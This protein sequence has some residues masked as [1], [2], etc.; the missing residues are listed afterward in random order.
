MS[1]ESQS[2]PAS[3]TPRDH[4]NPASRRALPY[5]PWHSGGM[6]WVSVARSVLRGPSKGETENSASREHFIEWSL[7]S[8]S[9]LL[10][11]ITDAHPYE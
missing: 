7:E 11:I 4:A 8:A 5:V 1:H 10:L 9:R 6:G 2:S 3:V